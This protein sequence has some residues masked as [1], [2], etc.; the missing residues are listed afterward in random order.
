MSLGLVPPEARFH[1][2]RRF[3][4]RLRSASAP[5][6]PARLCLMETSASRRSPGRSEAMGRAISS[7]SERRFRPIR[8][9]P[10]R[11]HGN[12]ETRGHQNFFPPPYA[13]WPERHGTS[14]RASMVGEHQPQDATRSSVR[15]L[16]PLRREW[17]RTTPRSDGRSS[18]TL[19]RSSRDRANRRRSAP[20]SGSASP[21]RT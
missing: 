13:R 7:R 1:G 14:R 21:N 8:T 10:V 2:D 20:K 5:E 11:R 3:L 4:H 6:L 17:G 12:P 19:R 18:H 15:S 16:R 9:G